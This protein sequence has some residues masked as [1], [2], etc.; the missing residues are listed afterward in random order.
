MTRWTESAIY[1]HLT[2]EFTEAKG[3]VMIPQVPNGTGAEKGR[4]A[5]ALAM[6]VWPSRGLHLY[7]FEIKVS[8]AD[9][10]K[11]LKSPA[12][13]ESVAQYCHYWAI[14]APSGIVPVEELPPLWGLLE[15]EESGTI[16]WTKRPA[17]RL[18]AV[19]ISLSFLAGVLRAAERAKSPQREKDAWYKKGF[20]A[21]V[22]QGKRQWTEDLETGRKRMQS[23]LQKL[24]QAERDL[25]YRLEGYE[26]AQQGVDESTMRLPRP[27]ED[28]TPIF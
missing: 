26:W 15:V 10:R 21:G 7:G 28:E 1:L 6:Q 19:P 24:R 27:E 16:Q 14:V 25:R 13:A 8:R 4:T 2:N 17:L 12:K 18:D 9:W 23:C 11:E 5:D 22:Q 20:D 3:F